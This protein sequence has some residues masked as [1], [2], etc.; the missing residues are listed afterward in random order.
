MDVV[1]DGRR[2][3]GRLAR[4]GASLG[5]SL[6]ALLAGCS[7]SPTVAPAPTP[8]VEPA[9]TRVGEGGRSAPPL[10]AALPAPP[11]LAAPEPVHSLDELRRQVALRLVAANPDLTYM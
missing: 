11:A 6:L 9:P 10:S 5:L 8:R 4:S 3:H 7:N 1:V 2:R